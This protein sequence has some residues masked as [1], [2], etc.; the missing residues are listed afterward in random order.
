MSD[1]KNH[2]A[3]ERRLFARIHFNSIAKIIIDNKVINAA[4]KDISIK[5]A[6]LQVDSTTDWQ[7]AIGNRCQIVMI[8][9]DDHQKI[10][11]Q[12]QIVHATTNKMI[13]FLCEHIDAQSIENLRNL[14]KSKFNNDALLE[15]ELKTLW[16]TVEGI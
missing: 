2:V 6:L 15:R 5:G 7:P 9:N 16:L 13:G 4:V 10:C 14:L 1:K 12:T 11:M 3:Q 8:E